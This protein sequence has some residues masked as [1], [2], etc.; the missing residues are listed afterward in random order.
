M[1]KQME[2]D[3]GLHVAP[4]RDG[5]QHVRKLRARRLEI[6]WLMARHGHDRF[7]DRAFFRRGHEQVRLRKHTHHSD[8]S[9]HAHS[10]ST[11]KTFARLSQG[12]AESWLEGSFLKSTITHCILGRVSFRESRRSDDVFK[13][14]ITRLLC[15]INHLFIRLTVCTTPRSHYA[16]RMLLPSLPRLKL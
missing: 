6:I 8:T 3:D 2:C 15:A 9:K 13:Q 16:R 11:T 12:T 5:G 10:L 7:G 14:S 4:T 1:S